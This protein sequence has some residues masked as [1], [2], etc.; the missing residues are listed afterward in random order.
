MRP[1]LKKLLGDRDAKVAFSAA[2]ALG[3]SGDS[4]GLKLLVK[5]VQ[6]PNLPAPM[7]C[8]AVE[9]LAVPDDP[10][11]A[12]EL[13]KL[14]DQYG[15]HDKKSPSNY[16]AELHAEL[17][18][19][20]ARHEDAADDPRFA[21]A[22]KSPSAAVRYESIKAWTASK[23]CHLPD[24]AADLRV[25]PDARVRAAAVEAIAAQKHPQ[26]IDYLRQNLTDSDFSVH[27][28]ALAGLGVLGGDEALEILLEQYR[29][30]SDGVR[31]EAIKALAAMK[32]EGPVIEAVE[33]KSWR[34]RQKTAESLA[35]FP[36]LAGTTAM[37][38][39]LTDQSP[40]VQTA[41]VRALEKWP[42]EKSGPLF[43]TAMGKSVI[44]ARKAAAEQLAEA[45]PPA[46]K[47]PVQGPSDHR[48]RVLR[49]L[50]SQF[51]NEFSEIR[52]CALDA[53]PAGKN[54]A[55]RVSPESMTKV[56]AL[57]AANDVKSLN[58]FGPEL[59]DVLE[60]MRFERNS[61]LPESVY[62][63]TLPRTR[64]VFA[65]LDRL[66]SLDMAERRQAA[67]ELREWAVKN[68]CGRLALDRLASLMAS[69]TDDLV[70]QSVLQAMANEMAYAALGHS[71]SE[72]RRKAC[73][74]LAEHPDRRHA[75]MLATALDDSQPLVVCAVLEALS[76][77]GMDDP[78]PL[79]KL[80]VSDNEEIQFATAKTLARID[81]PSGKPALERLAYSN[82]PLIRAKVATAMG[83]TPDPSYI[84][85]LIRFLN[86]QASVSRAALVSLPRVVGEDISQPTG[87]T[88]GKTSE[89]ISRWKRWFEQR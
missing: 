12:A 83:E 71:S 75:K 15:H 43:L 65:A 84:P 23:R 8:A 86:D 32:A 79:K 28:A 24:E 10:A 5:A 42:L 49:E 68:P 64:P 87:Q 19:G 34:V 72:V 21:A 76:A 2:I 50:T 89:R 67:I 11:V 57:I 13:K 63:Q 33:D 7:R 14:I 29:D 46:V 88:S 30:R 73:V 38:K 39:L 41:A 17:I 40:E 27:R 22:I 62:R 66:A 58:S 4:S 85:I 80:L 35:A 59:I 26:A 60:A 82:D 37:E 20:L 70:W 48:A 25:D 51:R 53:V 3:R 81:D 55:K 6:S 77:G 45:W 56:A 9:A 52:T 36:T 74:Y 44:A 54:V 78:S 69:E 18:R 1:D 31:A 61:T 16:N 47:F